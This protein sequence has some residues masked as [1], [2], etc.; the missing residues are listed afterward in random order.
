MSHEKDCNFSFDI[1]VFLS[2]YNFSNQKV[3]KK[4][5]EKYSDDQSCVTLVGEVVEFRENNVTIK[6]AELN[7]YIN[8]QGELCEYYVHCKKTLNLSVGDQIEFITVPFHFFNGHKLPIVEL[9]V[10]GTML[11]SRQEGKAD[12]IAWVNTNFG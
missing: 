8:Y 3:A 2:G 6:C 5:I 1:V 10:D 12:L 4:M 9:K 7:K 11:L